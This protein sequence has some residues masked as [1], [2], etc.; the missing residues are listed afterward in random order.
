MASLFEKINTL[1]SANMHSMVD[2]ALEQNSVAVMDEYIRQA[3]KDM[4]ELE[5]ST[6]QVGGSV[7]TL[8]RK[9][10]EF[11]DAAEKMD[12]DI[13]TL[14]LKGKDDL[15]AAAQTELNSKQQLA[16]EYYEQWQTQ[17]KQYDQMLSMR[18]KLEGRMTAIRQER[19]HLRSLI[20][21]TEAKKIT[22]KTIKSLDNL[23]STSDRDVANLADQIRN[24]LDTEDARLEMATQNLSEQIDDVVRSGEVERQ[25]EE[26][27]RRLL[28]AQGGSSGGSASAGGEST[29]QS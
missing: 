12:R 3:E 29:S 24:R 15:A 10:E 1:I 9:Y 19:E 23:A 22:N 7:R 20:E 5:E 26:R 27:R 16:Q 8:K 11:A 18:M 13:D 14:V 4:K 28:G 21:L 17:Q 2:R 6:A 25:L